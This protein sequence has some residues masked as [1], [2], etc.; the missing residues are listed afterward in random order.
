MKSG[1]FVSANEPKMIFVGDHGDVVKSKFVAR[2][3][4][5]NF[6]CERNFALVPLAV[7]ETV[8]DF[9][10]PHF[11]PAV[12]GRKIRVDTQRFARSTGHSD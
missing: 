4:V 2:T 12:G 7:V 3:A 5:L 10:V 1:I 6:G 8:P 9:N 11:D